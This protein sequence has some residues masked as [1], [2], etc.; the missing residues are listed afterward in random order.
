MNKE[1]PQTEKRLTEGKQLG[2]RPSSISN[3]SKVDLSKVKYC[4]SRGYTDKQLAEIFGVER[5]T[6]CN[7]KKDY[8]EFFNSLK[9]GKL[10]AD[11]KVEASLYQRACGYSHPEIHITN[12]QGVIIKTPIIK[13]YPPDPTSMIFW[14]KN[15]DREHWRDVTPTGETHIRAIIFN[16]QNS[17]GVLNQDE[18]TIL[19]D[20][21]SKR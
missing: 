1:N 2:G 4:G 11:A 21:N 3:I 5:T 14:L 13:H 20:A 12:Y 6:I 10:L 15:R 16:L 8:P 19:Q 17:P 18:Q 7:W 9:T